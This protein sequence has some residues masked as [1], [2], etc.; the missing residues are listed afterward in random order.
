MRSLNARILLWCVGTLV[1]ALLALAVGVPLLLTKPSLDLPLESP[2]PELKLA[3]AAYESGGARPLAGELDYLQDQFRRKYYF[4]DT[5]GQDLVTGEDRSELLTPLRPAKN[6]AGRAEGN[7]QGRFAVVDASPDGR[8]YLIGVEQREPAPRKQLLVYIFGVVTLV[9]VTLYAT[10]RGKVISPLR[11]LTASVDRFGA[12]DFSVRVG[13]TRRDEI[14]ELGRSFDRMA[15]RIE[16]LRAAERRLLQDVSHE[17]RTPLAR[18]SFAAELARTAED[19][20][21]AVAR[22]KKEINRLTALVGSLLQATRVE[23]EPAS[24][25]QETIRL[26]ELLREVIEDGRVEAEARGCGIT[27]D[28]RETVVTGD[29]ELLRRAIENVLRNAV[30]YTP[31]KSTVEVKLEN[32]RVSVRDYGPGVPEEALTRIFLPFYRVD[33]SRTQSTGGAG[34]GLA[35]AQRAVDLHRGRVWAENANPGLRVWMELP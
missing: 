34:L 33:D 9:L 12:G 28:A 30:R 4:L 18:M 14:G 25:N 2:A 1:A 27:L 11:G 8:Y 21:A 17:L 15:E 26:D 35:I 10:V 7:I 32:R 5:R 6:R 19:R 20:E 22:L 13:S 3:V 29:R 16:T 23:G 24:L 31:E